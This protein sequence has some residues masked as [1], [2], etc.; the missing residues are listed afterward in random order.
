MTTRLRN[1]TMAAMLSA[2]LLF[3]FWP[4]ITGMVGLWTR[5]PM[6]SYAFTVPFISL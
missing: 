4:A 3:A 1:I 2:A 6:Y 5:S